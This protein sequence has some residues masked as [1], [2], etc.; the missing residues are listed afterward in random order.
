MRVIAGSAKGRRL[1]VPRGVDLRPT[2]DSVREALFS[3]L[4]EDLKGRVVLDLFAGT[5]ALGI[6][7]LSR[8]AAHVTFVEKNPS[9]VSVIYENIRRCE[10]EARS[11]VLMQ[12]IP[13]DFPKIDRAVINRF[14]LV[15]IDPPYRLINRE[16]ILGG[17]VRF[18]FVRD[19][20]RIV[21]EHSPKKPFGSVPGGIS[22]RK[23]RRF[24]DT[25][26]TFFDYLKEEEAEAS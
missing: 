18:S 20:A 15:L 8:G 6:E 25:V 22:I 19:H 23:E 10:F 3:M 16:G 4:G 7:A 9:C 11:H 5:G 17:L 21:F 14:D 12:R 24:G 13:Q 1:K 2:K 26:L